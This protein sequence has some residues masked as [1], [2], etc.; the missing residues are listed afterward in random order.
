MNL[1][2]KHDKSFPK[3]N[4][5]WFAAEVATEKEVGFYESRSIKIRIFRIGQSGAPIESRLSRFRGWFGLWKNDRFLYLPGWREYL[6][7][8]MKKYE[9]IQ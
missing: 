6:E 4:L 7:E 5:Q 1:K 3:K 9:M 2:F 8:N